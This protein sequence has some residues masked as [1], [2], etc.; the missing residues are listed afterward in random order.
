MAEIDERPLR[1]HGSEVDEM[2]SRLVEC[3]GPHRLEQGG[4]TYAL[5]M[6]E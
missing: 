2:G 6:P 4:P 3:S 1:R 5:K